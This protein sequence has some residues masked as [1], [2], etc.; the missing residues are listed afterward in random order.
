MSTTHK[1]I[2]LSVTV[3]FIVGM[4]WYIDSTKPPAVA[5]TSIAIT[6]SSTTNAGTTTPSTSD[7]T[8]ILEQEAAMYSPAVELIPGGDPNATGTTAFGAP[9]S[10]GFINTAPFKLQDVIGKKVI[11][12]DFWTYSCINCMRT[13]PYLEAWES[14]YGNQGLLILGVQAPEFDFEKDYN[15]VLAAVERLGI[16]YPVMQDNNHATWDAYQNQYW[17]ADY[18]INIDGYITSTHFGEG[19]YAQTEAD[20]QAALTQRD[21]VLGLPGTVPTGTVNPSN[22]TPIRF[23]AVQSPETY[24]GA[25]RNEYLGNGTPSSTGTQQLT[26]ASSSVPQL[27][28][29]YLDGSWNFQNEYAG[30]QSVGAKI[31]YQYDAK[32]VY[33]VGSAQTPVDITILV[34]GKVVGHQTIQGDQLYPI[35][36]GAEYGQHTLEI[37]I[38]NP[39]LMAYTFTFG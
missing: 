35:V 28:T 19:D 33:M 11:L 31:L 25:A 36:Q 15:N 12:L 13:L 23:D 29:L 30:N 27:N 4:I 24:F 3:I 34:D 26:I 8:Q 6:A 17:P 1:N 5:P 7:R 37:L 21:Q 32:N 2:L 9:A 22:A 39:G 16:N 20:I 10:S 38:N 18:L 14:K